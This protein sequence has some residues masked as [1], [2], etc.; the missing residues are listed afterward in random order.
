MPTTKNTFEAVK[1]RIHFLFGQM[2]YAP[3]IPLCAL[4][5]TGVDKLLNMSIRMY[6]QLQQQIETSALNVALEKWLI[7]YPPP[8]GKQ[9]RFRLRYAVQVKANP[10][11]F[12]FFV[13]RP[14]AVG[15]TYVSYL[16]NRIRRD[17][18]FSLIPVAIELRP[19]SKN[20]R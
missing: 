9:S 6:K 7:E 1:D 14:H 16:R 12:V 20:R 4:D 13:S 19:S 5:G 18:G 8:S 15:D 2:E 3:I 11:K 10:V 17:L